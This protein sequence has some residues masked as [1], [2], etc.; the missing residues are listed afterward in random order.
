[1][2]AEFASQKHTSLDNIPPMGGHIPD[3]PQ[4][5]DTLARSYEAWSLSRKVAAK[6][7]VEKSTEV[8]P[9]T[10][11][12]TAP[13]KAPFPSTHEGGINLLNLVPRRVAKAV[14]FGLVVASLF[15]GCDAGTPTSTQPIPTS[16]PPITNT[17]VPLENR[18]QLCVPAAG[19]S[20]EP[21]PE[22]DISAELQQIEELDLSTITP[23]M[24]MQYGYNPENV[25]IFIISNIENEEERSA[26]IENH[27]AELRKTYGLI[28][29]I[30]FVNFDHIKVNIPTSTGI[31]GDKEFITQNIGGRVL[32]RLIER[33]MERGVYA[34]TALYIQNTGVYMGT[35]DEAAFTTNNHNSPK[36]IAGHEIAHTKVFFAAGAGQ[37]QRLESNLSLGESYETVRVT[38]ADFGKLFH[39]A[40]MTST[41]VYAQQFP[42]EAALLQ[43]M[44]VPII[45]TGTTRCGN[46]PIQTIEGNTLTIMKNDASVY[47]IGDN[48]TRLRAFELAMFQLNIDRTRAWIKAL[49]ENRPFEFSEQNWINNRNNWNRFVQAQGY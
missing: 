36:I 49:R 34:N 44:N 13:R 43:A 10:G 1:M 47:G 25:N 29:G 33:L 48:Q 39:T 14:T 3:Q 19:K 18:V 2:L 27:V 38:E 8:I 42:V 12:E 16:A 24:L 4:L 7:S 41:E 23:E 35:C 22:R 26:V 32:R 30:S 15:T 46:F 28:D 5:Q 11:Q 31:D 6:E 9:A 40:M 17:V 37:L 45:D 20:P 21:Q